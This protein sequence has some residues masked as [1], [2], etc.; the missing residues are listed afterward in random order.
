[1]FS[2]IIDVLLPPLKILNSTVFLLFEGIFMA[3]SAIEEAFSWLGLDFKYFSELFSVFS[4]IREC[5]ETLYIK[6]KEFIEFDFCEKVK[7][8]T[9][10]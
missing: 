8:N 4:E 9:D 1:M 7:N 2:S 10:L 5:M 6:V 3:L